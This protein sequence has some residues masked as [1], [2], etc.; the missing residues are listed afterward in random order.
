MLAAALYAL[1]PW[2]TWVPQR[3]TQEHIDAAVLKTL[4]EKPLPSPGAKA[5]ANVI[6]SVVRVIGMVDDADKPVRSAHDVLPPKKGEGKDEAKG[7]DKDEKAVTPPKSGPI[8]DE[9]D[10]KNTVGTGVV[11]ID[12]GTILTNLHV[13]LGAKRVKVEFAD[14]LVSDADLV[15]TRPEHDLAVLRA[16][17]IPDDL[18]AA[19]MRSRG[20]GAGGRG[21][22]HAQGGAFLPRRHRGRLRC[23]G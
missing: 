4:N 12:N 16:R 5:Y 9:D 7:S 23:V 15:G 10:D 19:T 2:R 8:P 11:I 1:A 21:R 3:L 6:G 13:V 18:K 14:G 20:D 17:R 22:A